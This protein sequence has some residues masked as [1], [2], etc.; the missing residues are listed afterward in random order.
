[1]DCGGLP[2]LCVPGRAETRPF[3]GDGIGC[4]STGPRRFLEMEGRLPRR[5]TALGL[6]EAPSAGFPVG[7]GPGHQRNAIGAECP[8]G[9]WLSS[10]R[11]DC[12]AVGPPG[13]SGV[14]GVDGAR[15]A[16]AGPLTEHVRSRLE[17]WASK[18]PSSWR[19]SNASRGGRR[20]SLTRQR[21]DCG[22][23]VFADTVRA[24]LSCG[25]VIGKRSRILDWV[26]EFR[27]GGAERFCIRGTPVLGRQG[28][29][30]L[31]N[32]ASGGAKGCGN[33]WRARQDSN[34]RPPA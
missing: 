15:T 12:D 31:A 24:S 13:R 9:A 22:G 29:A 6:E 27:D 17:G 26:G 33:E 20:C 1:M 8:K 5:L 16:G 14:R 11:D 3:K 30:I 4:R 34:L 32:E 28:G 21:M 10:W 7:M 23:S 2:P 18:A 25:R 19:T